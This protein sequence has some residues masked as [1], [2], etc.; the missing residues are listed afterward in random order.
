MDP[1]KSITRL[2]VELQRKILDCLDRRSMLKA[3]LVCKTWNDIISTSSKFLDSTRFTLQENNRTNF[4]MTR[5]Y[6]HLSITAGDYSLRKQNLQQITV[7][8]SLET[9]KL[10]PE[11]RV[12]WEFLENPWDI[13]E[14]EKYES[15]LTLE[16]S[17][18]FIEFLKRC[19]NL[20]T[21]HISL[22]LKTVEIKE[23]KLVAKLPKL[24]DLTLVE[25]DWLLKYLD[26]ENLEKLCIMRFQGERIRRM[27]V[28]FGDRSKRE[29]E[30]HIV[31]LMNKSQH[32][33]QIDFFGV[34]M[35]SNINLEPKFEWSSLKVV[36]VFA[37]MNDNWQKLI[38][39]AGPDSK[40][41]VGKEVFIS[42]EL[43][44]MVKHQPNITGLSFQLRTYEFL[45]ADVDESNKLPNITK[46]QMRSLQRLN[47]SYEE[48]MVVDKMTEF[49]SR[50]ENVAFLDVDSYTTKFIAGGTLK[51][52]RPI[53]DKV[54]HLK[55]DSLSGCC[56]MWRSVTF[57]SLETLEVCDVKTHL[58][59]TRAGLSNPTLRKLIINW[60][61]E[62]EPSLWRIC[63][64][65]FP[66]VQEFVHVNPLTD[67]RVS[68]K[69]RNDIEQMIA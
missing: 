60:H 44:M 6:R 18:D 21:L 4:R 31:E 37:Q 65:R 47:N 63:L 22:S 39:A 33:N 11:R 50:L 48:L 27:P 24:R 1:Q 30:D 64:E 29:S 67:E 59:V 68:V 23:C 52:P 32:L 69:S 7:Y 36:D 8:E 28:F 43:L 26:V 54:T 12:F 2:P 62:F 13:P 41:T 40:I 51:R 17:A 9:L 57:P 16:S 66:T 42:S 25:C 35:K 15:S 10:M 14:L 45:E 19:V 49:M 20:K 5:K 38:S 46:L 58:K 55:V 53:F 34:H 3:A 61:F 56:K